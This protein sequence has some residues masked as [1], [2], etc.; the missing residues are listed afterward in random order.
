MG[1]IINHHTS[2]DVYYMSLAISE[3]KKGCFTT[4]P[5]P[6]VGCVIVKNNLII[7]RGFHPKSG[8]PHAEVY[9]LKD[10]QDQDHDVT[11]ATV[12]VTLEPCSHVGRT[13]PCADA[14][15]KSGVARVVI[16]CMDANLLV[17]GNG[18]KKLVDAG[19]DVS[20]GVCQEEAYALNV[21]FLTAMKRGRPYVRLKMAMS[22]DGRIAMQGGES[23]WITGDD[24]REDVQRL[25]ARSGA[26]ITGSGTVIADNP[27]LN[28]RSATLGLDLSSFSQ[29]RIV[30]VDRRNRLDRGD[31]K[32][33]QREDTLI[34]RKDLHELLRWLHHDQCYD[35]LIEAGGRLAG[36]FIEEDLV[37]ELVIYQAPCVLG[38]KTHAAFEMCLTQLSEQKR[39]RLVSHERLGMDLKLVL[40]RS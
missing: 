32:V 9:A 7:G 38:V 33:L 1:S 37:D 39:F 31:Y 25:R 12:Y 16:A 4:R 15:I 10:A 8:L 40:V 22:L 35:V 18:V 14:L 30:I 2:A 28:V 19:I 27:S 23:Q 11:G 6:N 21:G 36:A 20:V 26:I 17:C 34:W 13:P 29:P 24:A 5:N 3:A